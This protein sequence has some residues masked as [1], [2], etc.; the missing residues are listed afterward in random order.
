MNQVNFGWLIRSVHAWGANLMILFCVLH[1]LRVFFQGAYKRPREVTWVVGVVLAAGHPG[2]WLYR[3]P[4]ALGP[5]GLLGYHGWHRDR[6][7]DAAIGQPLA[8]FPA[9]RPDITAR[10]LSRFFGVHV[11]VLPLSV[12]LMLVVHLTMVHQQ[13]WLTR[14]REVDDESCRPRFRSWHTGKQA[15][16]VAFLSQLHVGRG[17]R[18]VRDVGPADRLGLALPGRGWRNLP[19]RLR[20]PAHTKPEWYFLFLYQGLKVVSRMMGV[21]LPIVGGSGS[22]AVALPGSQSLH[23]GPPAADRHQSGLISL[24]GIVTLPSGAG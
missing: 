2:L 8:V 7:R 24:I 12:I 5:A 15:K 4:A 10:T 22:A 19:I 9:R 21:T 20:T 1:L 17:H 11:L 18:V 16:A 14:T 13:G 6:R 3:L 23:R